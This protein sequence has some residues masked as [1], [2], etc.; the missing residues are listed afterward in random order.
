MLHEVEIL[1]T[2]RIAGLAATARR[3]R[4][5]ALSSVDPA[6][7]DVAA[8]ARGT[9]HPEGE[10][11]LDYV[12]D[13]DS[14]RRLLREAIDAVPPEVR[15]RIWAVMRVGRGDF[16]GRDWQAAIGAADRELPENISDSLSEE[17]ELHELLIK[18]LH[19]LRALGKPA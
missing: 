1:E 16:A 18:G 15:R 8:P 10:L 13:A 4:D 5:R 7:L 6:K 12:P 14:A 19:E 3:A 11:G 2:R 17:I 9:H